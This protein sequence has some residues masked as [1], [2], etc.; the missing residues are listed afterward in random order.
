WER[1]GTAWTGYLREPEMP[2]SVDELYPLLAE[3]DAE[4]HGVVWL[5]PARF[6]DG[7]GFAMAEDLAEA[8][9]IE[10]LTD[11]ARYIDDGGLTSI[12]VT[13]DFTTFP[14]EGRVDFEELLDVTLADETLRVWDPEPIY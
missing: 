9:G 3:R 5:S 14:T 8:L 1:M 12:C 6:S 7:A 13:S 10:T 2:D 4:E 11:M